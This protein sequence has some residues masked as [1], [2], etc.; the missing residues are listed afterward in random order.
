MKIML[1]E[2]A[3]LPVRSHTYDA[4]MDLYAREDQLI[5]PGDSRIFDTGVHIS[6]PE[7]FFAEVRPKSGL[8]FRHKVVAGLGTVDCGYTGSVQV[9]LFNLGKEA[10]QV[11]RGDRIA[12][13]VV[14]PCVLL[15]LEQTKA[16]ET[17]D[18]GSG[19]FGSTGR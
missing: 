4:G 6:V 1:D 9:I 5:P 13:L 7:S 15:P 18:R 19:G 12:Q 2:G 8:M 10:Y 11:R 16:L 14:T 17:S 3:Q